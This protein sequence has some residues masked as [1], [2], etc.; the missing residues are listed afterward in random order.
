MKSSMP[1]PFPTGPAPFEQGTNL[2]ARSFP[3]CCFQFDLKGDYGRV[4]GI[5]D[6]CHSVMSNRT[7][8]LTRGVFTFHG[9]PSSDSF[10]S[11]TAGV[12]GHP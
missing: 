9:T 10:R 8:H 4:S 7:P 5:Q 11:R 3:D 12:S 1:P 2:P 6:A